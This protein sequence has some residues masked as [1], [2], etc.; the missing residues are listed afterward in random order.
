MEAKSIKSILNTLGLTFLPS[1]CLE[2]SQS[3][4]FSNKNGAGFSK[5]SV[6]T[7]MWMFSGNAWS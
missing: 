2:K 4:M 7:F 6:G 3:G 5:S 1:A